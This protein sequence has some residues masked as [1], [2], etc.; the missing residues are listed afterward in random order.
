MPRPVWSSGAALVARDDLVAAL[1]PRLKI[2]LLQDCAPTLS[3]TDQLA[4]TG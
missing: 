1:A 3:R 2:S 4:I